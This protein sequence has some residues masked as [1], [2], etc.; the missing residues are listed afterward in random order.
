MGLLFLLVNKHF[1][2]RYTHTHT[3]KILWTPQYLQH[4]EFLSPSQVAQFVK[5]V[6]RIHQSFR[7]DPQSGHIQVST[8][9][10]GGGG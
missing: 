9:D 5:S 8:E 6:V 3:K 7:F 4:K 10:G 2:N 1:I